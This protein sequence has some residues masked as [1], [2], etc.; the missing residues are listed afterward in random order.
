MR[1]IIGMLLPVLA[2][3][4]VTSAAAQAQDEVVKG[5]YMGSKEL[6]ERAKKEGVG[7]VAQEGNIVLSNEGLET[8]EYNCAFLQFLKNPRM[9]AAWTVVSM[10]EEPDNA[11]PE[12]FSVVE[13]TAGELEIAALSET[14]V[15]EAAAAAE[16]GEE[17]PAQGETTQPEPETGSSPDSADTEEENTGVS[18]TYYRCEGLEK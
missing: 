9:P 1:K 6:C 12:L 18:G 15:A 5:L 2:L 7:E 13:R 3:T 11:V 4:I 10:C 8:V 16:T 17:T 14:A